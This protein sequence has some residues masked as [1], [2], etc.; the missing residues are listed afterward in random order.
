M[1]MAVPA[2]KWQ[3]LLDTLDASSGGG[4]VYYLKEPKTRIRLVLP[5]MS[6]NSG[7]DEDDEEIF[8]AETTK[9]YQGKASSAFIVM[10][11][12]LGTSTKGDKNVSDT[13]V[14]AIR[15]PKT[16]LRWV[17]S[18]L[19]EEHELFDE[20][21]G[22]GVTIERIGGG[23]SDRTSYSGG[24]SAKPIPIQVDKLEW[25]AKDIW[26]IAAEESTRSEQRDA[27]KGG[28]G[29]AKSRNGRNIPQEV[30]EEDEDLPF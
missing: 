20:V 2:S 25:P 30:E 16:A 29:K 4:D 8:Y 14:R 11:L 23:N 19:A 26:T 12:I 7:G 3:D 22:H 1:I 15:L 6:P 24:V 9:H 17:V 13:K 5:A 27:K 21:S 10:G 18:Q 28:D